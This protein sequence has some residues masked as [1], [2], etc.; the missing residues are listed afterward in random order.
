MALVFHYPS[1]AD[2]PPFSALTALYYDDE[3]ERSGDL[4]LFSHYSSS[5]GLAVVPPRPPL[6]G[7]WQ[8]FDPTYQENFGINPK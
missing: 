6:I 3:C 5:G 4:A 1:N 7:A 8:D 2:R